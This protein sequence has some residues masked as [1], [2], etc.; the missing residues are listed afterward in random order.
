[1]S[2]LGW[3]F[4]GAITGWL[5]S[6]IV[7]NR[8]EGCIVNIALGLV[9]SLVGGLIFR[10]IS[11]FDVFGFNFTSMIVSILGAVIV[12]FLWHAVTGRRTLR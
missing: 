9:G 10:A 7:N 12:L 1:M 2:I 5:A 4:F 3:L 6:L 11:D 8:G